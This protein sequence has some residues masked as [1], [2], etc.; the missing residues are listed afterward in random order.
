MTAFW[1]QFSPPARDKSCE[2]EGSDRL[3]GSVWLIPSCANWY[4]LE[5]TMFDTLSPW[6]AFKK[7]F[8]IGGGLAAGGYA[9]MKV[10]DGI[11]HVGASIR[12]WFRNRPATENK[13][14]KK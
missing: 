9:T 7:A 11:L 3:S 6:G 8:V 2:S 14:E 5:D 1:T 10:G 12:D 13:Q 4:A